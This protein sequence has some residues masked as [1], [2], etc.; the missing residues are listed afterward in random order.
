MAAAEHCEVLDQDSHGAH[1]LLLCV[2]S[3]LG[4]VPAKA[5]LK[6]KCGVL[7]FTNAKVTGPPGR[8]SLACSDLCS[9]SEK[10]Q[11]FFM[12]AAD[13]ALFGVQ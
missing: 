1:S 3:W 8:S 2:G 11:G 13:V 7:V 9:C 5:L 6:V 10:K 12:C 4:R